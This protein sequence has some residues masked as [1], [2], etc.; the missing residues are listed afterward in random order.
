MTS[1]H[2][3]GSSCPRRHLLG[4][5]LAAPHRAH[6]DMAVDIEHEDVEPGRIDGLEVAAGTQGP[7]CE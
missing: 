1:D 6:P 5:V 7:T 2:A 3:P 4:L